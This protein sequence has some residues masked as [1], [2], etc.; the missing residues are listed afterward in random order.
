MAKRRI[1]IEVEVDI[2]VPEATEKAYKDD[3][4]SEDDM[5]DA[6]IQGLDIEVDTTDEVSC[7]VGCWVE[8]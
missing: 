5:F 3:G 8:K 1:R 6:I 2:I 4:V 7:E